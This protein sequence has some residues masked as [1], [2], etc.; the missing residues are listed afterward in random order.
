MDNV[1]DTVPVRYKIH[2]EPDLDR[3]LF[4]GRTE[5]VVI[6]EKTVTEISLNALELAVW[7]CRLKKEREEI[8]CPF[9]MD[10]ENE[11]LNIKLP[12]PT[13]G[14]VCLVME[15][16]GKINNKM[17]GF[18]RSRAVINGKEQYIGVTQFEES[19]ARR[20]FPCFDHPLYKAVFDVE[21]IIDKDLQAVSNSDIKDEKIL[22][23][24]RKFVRF[25]ETPKMSTYLLFF[26]LGPFEFIEDPGKV[27][28]RVGTMPGMIEQGRFGL[29]FG[30]KSLSFSEDYYD[31]KYPLPKLDLIAVSD[32]AA[33]AME[34]WGAITFRENLLLY[35]SK[36]TSKSG[37]MRICEV[38]AH[39][40]AHQ[41]FGNLVTPSDWKYLWLNE[42]FATYFGFGIVDHYYPEWDVW[43]QFIGSQTAVAFERDA[44][45]NTIPME[46][47][48]GEHVVINTSTAPIIYNKGGSIL[49]QIEGYIGHK[50]F[51][52]GLRFYLKKYAYKCAAS[53]QLWEAFENVSEK[54]VKEMMKRWVEQ[55]G[56]PVVEVARDGETLTATQKRFS[57]LPSRSLNQDQEWIVPLTVKVFY[58]D[59]SSRVVTTLLEGKSAQIEAGKEILAYKVNHEQT[60]FY[61]VKYSDNNLKALYQLI[62]DKSLSPIDRWGVES[63]MY[64]LLKGD[65]VSLGDFMECLSAFKGDTSFL[66]VIGLSS[67]CSHLWLI[68]GEEWEGS[69][70]SLGRTI[71]EGVLQETGLYPDVD[72]G[73]T[74]SILRDE[75][76]WFAGLFG[77]QM[78]RD[79]A[80]EKLSIIME[81][82]SV[83]PDIAKGVMKVAALNG[84]R[85]ILDWLMRKFKTSN[86]EHERINILMALGKFQDKALIEEVRQFILENVPDRNK[87]F[88]IGSLAENPVAVEDLWEWYKGSLDK[89][90]QFHPVHY[91]RVIAAIVPVAGI[92]KE[93]EVKEFFKDYLK[94]NEKLRDLVD[95]SLERLE[96]N[97]RL[98]KI[99]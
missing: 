12:E 67:H 15:F 93:D 72:E 58:K 46:I 31:V 20:A 83:H 81:G 69:I 63:D 73:F 66:P 68:M 85:N 88:P 14:E 59:G 47:P 19:D 78:A 86:N 36:V 48:G 99:S 30:R 41:W 16:M 43:D 24:G 27:L 92:G 33:G 28:V 54:P 7:E 77:S 51:K 62:A 8:K 35:D 6:L 37:K 80:L 91:E 42:S 13:D 9:S 1:K 94:K 49:R 32:F 29:E 22:E 95:L 34:N 71:F 2:L 96:I 76:I 40:M 5:T 52:E 44:Y 39:E 65:M 17:A 53:H 3:F 84:D 10:P 87:F 50:K 97:S 79:F 21:M 23:D 11:L 26:G 64:A 55:P 4:Y 70:S 25:S 56:Y 61:R 60:G 57:Y 89:L 75:S 90:E 45:R 38:I 18:Y 74:K 98:V 82:G